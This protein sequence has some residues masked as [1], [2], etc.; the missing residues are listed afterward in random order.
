MSGHSK[1]ST[2]KRQKW[3]QDAK[4]AAVF[5]R[6][7]RNIT[8]AAREGGGDSDTNFK[9]RLAMDKA[10]GANMPKDNIERAIKKGT[11]ELKGEVLE[12]CLYEGMGP[13]NIQFIIKSL[14]DNRNRS[15]SSIKHLFNKYGGAF[16]P[17]MWNFKE[18]GVIRVGK[19]EIAQKD[20]DPEEL[21][22]ELI[23]RGIEDMETE[24]EGVTIYT[25]TKDLAVIKRF[26]DSKSIEAETADIE[27]IPLQTK[28]V[29]D[30]EKESVEKFMEELEDCEDVNDY[31][32]NCEF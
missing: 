20:I 13:A 15:A 22:L 12:E 14:T 9:L 32:N 10:K 19:D 17:V 26:L 7:A 8:V 4:R 2:I 28:K 3:A 6:L 31:Y 29:E 25:E 5:T 11:G 18:R 23:E 24:E 30:K 16:T 27:Y 21:E 1:W